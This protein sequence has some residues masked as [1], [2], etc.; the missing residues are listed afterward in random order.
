MTLFS[1]PK[2]C[3]WVWQKIGGGRQNIWLGAN[4]QKILRAEMSRK[5][6]SSMHFLQPLM[7]S[8]VYLEEQPSFAI[9][10]RYKIR[11]GSGQK[12]EITNSLFRMV[13]LMILFL[14]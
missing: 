1:Q 3:G 9:S 7:I 10:E 5:A 12:N 14:T 8:F 6:S 13:F 4:V 2:L 11:Q